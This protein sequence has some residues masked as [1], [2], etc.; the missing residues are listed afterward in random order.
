MIQLLNFPVS[1]ASRLWLNRFV[2]S[3]SFR[4]VASLYDNLAIAMLTLPDVRC[5]LLRYDPRADCW[6]FVSPISSPRDALGACRLGDRIYVVGGCDGMRYVN[7]VECYDPMS[8]EWK[9]VRN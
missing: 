4:S 1:P 6:S 8:N 2:T 9:P 7:T 3:F 5:A